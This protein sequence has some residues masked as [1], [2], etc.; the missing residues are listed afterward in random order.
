MTTKIMKAHRMSPSRR[1]PT[2]VS[3]I[4]GTQVGSIGHWNASA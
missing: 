3:A 1:K 2:S 4:V